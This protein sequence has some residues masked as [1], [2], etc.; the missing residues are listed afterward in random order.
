MTRTAQQYKLARWLRAHGFD[1]QIE[2]WVGNCGITVDLAYPELRLAV[3]VDGGYHD[4]WSQK[5]EDACRD[6][7]LYAV[8]WECIRVKNEDIDGNLASA[9]YRILAA[10]RRRATR[11][12]RQ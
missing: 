12:G 5:Q 7:T 1:P 6:R 8:G 4:Q 10:L 3:E 2:C 9:G 11:A